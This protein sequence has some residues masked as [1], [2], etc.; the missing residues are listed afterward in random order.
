VKQDEEYKSENEHTIVPVYRNPSEFLG[1]MQF[2][3]FGKGISDPDGLLLWQGS[4]R[5]SAL[6]SFD[7]ESIAI[8]QLP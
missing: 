1:P 8:N 6:L 5:A 7:G 4:N 3:V 2:R